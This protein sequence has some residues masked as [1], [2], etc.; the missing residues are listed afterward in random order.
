MHV[1]FCFRSHLKK[2]PQF[3]FRAQIDQA[4]KAM[5]VGPLPIVAYVPQ[6]SFMFSFISKPKYAKMAVKK[7]MPCHFY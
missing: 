4:S 6:K 5:A 7:M 3:L 1:C 2:I